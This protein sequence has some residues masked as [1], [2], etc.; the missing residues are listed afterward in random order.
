[1]GKALECAQDALNHEPPDIPVGCVIVRNGKIISAAGNTRESEDRITGHAEINALHAA[2]SVVGSRFLD[3]CQAYVTLEPCPMCAGALRD[4]HIET[5]YFGAYNLKEGAAGT[6]YNILYP[7]VKVF[8]G[9][10]KSDC[11]SLLKNY[12]NKLRR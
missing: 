9:I 6:V 12:F 11:E 5:V 8:G 10:K 2:A 7:R 3:G 1:M 4:A